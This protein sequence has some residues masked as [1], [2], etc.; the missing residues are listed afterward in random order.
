M[1]VLNNTPLVTELEY[2]YKQVNFVNWLSDFAYLN[3]IPV[4]NNKIS[5]N[6]KFAKGTSEAYHV[7]TGLS[8]I[9]HNYTLNNGIS[10][11]RNASANK[12]I[13]IHFNNIDEVA[14]DGNNNVAT[15]LFSIQISSTQKPVEVILAK[16]TSIQTISIYI[17][18]N[19]IEKNILSGFLP[20]INNIHYNDVIKLMPT[21]KQVTLLQ[22]ILKHQHNNI[23]ALAQSKIIDQLKYVTKDILQLFI[24]QYI[25][26][27]N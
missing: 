9:V 22:S 16:N 6:N 11:K 21:N 7:A 12:G 14:N 3:N 24:E 25:A 10:F 18:N 26:K 2:R 20:L 5:Y 17:E 4:E 13:L 23:K 19:W 8:S 1:Q 27:N 15:N